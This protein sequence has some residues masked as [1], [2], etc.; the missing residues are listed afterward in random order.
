MSCGC[1]KTFFVKYITKN[2]IFGKHVIL[3]NSFKNNL[4]NCFEASWVRLLTTNDNSQ[5]IFRHVF[6]RKHNLTV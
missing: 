5:N 6:D 4:K 1:R 3:H 2:E